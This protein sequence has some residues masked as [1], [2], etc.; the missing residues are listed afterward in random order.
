MM[1]TEYDTKRI[2]W[3]HGMPVE[4]HRNG[5][6][7]R[8]LLGPCPNCGTSTSNYGFGFSCH[9]DH[10]PCS[11]DNFACSAG[12]IP[13]WWNTGVQVYM[14]GDM[15]CAVGPDFINLQESHAGFGKT[16][17][18]AVDALKERVNKAMENIE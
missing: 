18:A 12:P 17:R 2:R 10:C 1:N 4:W 16:P 8:R 5:E 15:W 11:A 7:R 13:D 14:D 6:V 9:N 3:A